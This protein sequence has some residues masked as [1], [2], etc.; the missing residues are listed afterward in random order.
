MKYYLEIQ[1]HMAYSI[2]LLLSIN[3]TLPFNYSP[4]IHIY[5]PLVIFT[6]PRQGTTK[7]IYK[8]YFLLLRSILILF[9]SSN[10]IPASRVSLSIFE[11][12]ISQFDENLEKSFWNPASQIESSNIAIVPFLPTLMDNIKLD[13][14][15]RK[16]W[17][18][19]FP[20]EE[21]LAIEVVQTEKHGRVFINREQFRHVARRGTIID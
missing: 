9:P 21:S 7:F 12:Y 16:K 4:F 5:P 8:I 2:F 18:H 6:N 17:G 14:F 10:Q 15:G 13:I 3:F 19:F 11:K 20:D 1:Y